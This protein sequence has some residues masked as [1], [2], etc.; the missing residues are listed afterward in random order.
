MWHNEKV[1]LRAA[2]YQGDIHYRWH[3]VLSK[4]R[5]GEDA[6][7]KESILLPCFGV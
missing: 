4:G 2:V 1:E 3:F 7:L 6:G 5:E